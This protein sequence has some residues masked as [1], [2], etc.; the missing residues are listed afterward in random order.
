MGQQRRDAERIKH[1]FDS[2]PLYLGGI[3]L[4]KK[5]AE[6]GLRLPAPQGNPGLL[7]DRAGGYVK[8]MPQADQV[9]VD[10][11]KIST[12]D[13]PQVW[14]GEASQRASDVNSAAA[15]EVDRL[16]AV[17]GEVGKE[18][19]MLSDA[20]QTA[21][22]KHQ[23]GHAAMRAVR[24]DLDT[25]PDL[26]GLF[27]T[28]RAE[29]IKRNGQA[30]AGL[31]RDAA[32]IADEAGRKAAS[33][34]NDLA[35]QARAA[36]LSNAHLDSVDT[37]VLTQ[38]AAPGDPEDLNAILTTNDAERAGQ[39]L[40]RMSE[41]DRSRIDALLDNATSPQ[42]K[43]YLMKAL[44]AGHDINAIQDFSSKIHAH[45]GDPQWLRDRLTPILT[46]DHDTTTGV[47]DSVRYQG[48][49][50][51]QGQ[52]PTCVAYSTMVARAQADPLYGV[53]V[54]HRRPPRRPWTRQPARV[55]RTGTGRVGTDLRRRPQD[56]LA[57]VRPR[58]RHEHQTGHLRSQQ[59]DQPGHRWPLRA[60]R[61]GPRRRAPQRA[62]A[63]RACRR[64]GQAGARPG[65]WR[66]RRTPDDDHRTRRRQ[67]A[68]LQP[69]GSHGLGR[70]G[71]LHQRP[72]GRRVQ[73]QPAHRHRRAPTPKIETTMAIEDEL[74]QLDLPAL[75]RAGLPEPEG[76]RRRT[77]F[78]DG[79]VAAAVRLD[80]LGTYPRSVT[81]LAEVARSG[82]N[83]YAA[84][85]PEPLPTPEQTEMVRPWLAAAAQVTS[86]IDQDATL[87]DWLEAVAALLATRRSTRGEDG[88]FLIPE[89]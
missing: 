11:S 24:A 13:V 84:N 44:A 20:L 82:G 75:V 4:M 68:D 16:V 12:T 74:T 6:D 64:R 27:D 89:V 63:D 76:P 48:A 9:S 79:A 71:R 86:T 80:Q 70:Q 33:R 1:A 66:W 2:V 87:A 52:R 62:A 55:R 39:Y 60:Q 78:G 72:P 31:L 65:P 67:V 7:A 85:L 19:D 49:E 26:F 29:Q 21:Q 22:A 54:D 18:L 42:E 10:L 47:W 3:G 45:G 83:R 41:Q 36:T 77:L 43:A 14:V 37:L 25:V 46:E 51:T 88:P 59:G 30:A 40:D 61:P 58:R 23:D 5:I 34:L 57:S 69:V 17:Y 56:R 28:G 8:A 81:F 50:W 32:V 73:R 35:S 38:A 53:A 15:K